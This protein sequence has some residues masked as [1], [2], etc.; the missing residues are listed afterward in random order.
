[1]ELSPAKEGNVDT[2]PRLQ[3]ER[4]RKGGERRASRLLRTTFSM[5]KLPEAFSCLFL[6]IVNPFRTTFD[7]EAKIFATIPD[8]VCRWFKMLRR[9]IT[10]WM[11]RSEPFS[12]FSRR[13]SPEELG[14]FSPDTT[15][16]SFFIC[17][18]RFVSGCYFQRNDHSRWNEDNFRPV[19]L[20]T[21]YARDLPQDI[22]YYLFSYS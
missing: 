7:R 15:V 19:T 20:W 2:H 4:N 6:P 18:R 16:G 9:W 10:S 14:H 1:M 3:S 11:S 13:L 22:T 12:S 8:S 21:L 5:A 17:A